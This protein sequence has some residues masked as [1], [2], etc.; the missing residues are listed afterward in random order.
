MN[1]RQSIQSSGWSPLAG[2]SPREECTRRQ[3]PAR[4]VYRPREK[5]A[6]EA[7]ERSIGTRRQ[8]PSRGAYPAPAAD[9]YSTPCSISGRLRGSSQAAFGEPVQGMRVAPLPPR[10]TNGTEPPRRFRTRRMPMRPE[11]GKNRAGACRGRE[12]GGAAG[13]GRAAP[14]REPVG[15]PAIDWA[16]PICS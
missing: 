15:A 2:R 4:G 8:K 7:R 3:K 1:S 6:A 11:V 5:P 10:R 14:Q 9:V 12:A 16:R 13:P